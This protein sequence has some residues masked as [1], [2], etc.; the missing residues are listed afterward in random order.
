MAQ[1][2]RSGK[3]SVGASNPVLRYGPRFW[4]LPAAWALLAPLEK[5]A[6]H[7]TF[8]NSVHLSDSISSLADAAALRARV[9]ELEALLARERSRAEHLLLINEVGRRIGAI[10]NQEDLLQQVV[11]LIR[12]RLWY[13]RVNVLLVHGT[14]VVLRAAAGWSDLAAILGL[15]LPIGT[16]IVGWVAAHAEPLLVN[17]VSLDPRHVRESDPEE[18]WAELAVPIRLGERVLGVLDVQASERN[19]FTQDDVFT[20]E[21]LAD[22]IAV[23]LENARIY[24]AMDQHLAEVLALQEV[25]T[26]IMGERDARR[27]M[28]TVAKQA[29]SLLGC[30]T[31]SLELL[32]VGRPWLEVEVASGVASEQLLGTRVPLDASL[33]GHVLRTGR[34]LISHEAATDP[35]TH[36][37]TIRRT[38]ARSLLVAPMGLRGRRMGTISAY[39]KHFGQFTERDAELMALFGGQAAVAIENARLLDAERR[40]ARQAE[41]LARASITIN[42][43]LDLTRTLDVITRQVCETLDAERVAIFLHDP[44]SDTVYVGSTAGVSQELCDRLKPLRFSRDTAKAFRDTWSGLTIVVEDAEA[45]PE[46]NPVSRQMFGFRSFMATPL[47]VKGHYLG[48]LFVDQG[49]QLRH[50]SD[51]DRRLFEALAGPVA[52]AVENARLHAEAQRLAVVEERT[53]LARELH[54]SVT[55]SLF[56]AS[57]LAQ[58]AQSLWKRDPERAKERLDRAAE[59]CGGALA[60]MRALIF[61]LRPAALQEEGLVSALRKHAAAREA[62][63]GIAVEFAVEHERRLP[64]DCEEAAYRIVREALH[65]IVKH[66]RASAVRVR[67]DFQPDRLC[68]EVR[69][70]GQGFDVAAV[71]GRG[72]GLTSMRERA[73]QLGGSLTIESG[74]G[75]GTAIRAELPVPK[76]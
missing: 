12:Q 20:L 31:V 73:E 76:S 16:G 43:S 35:R 25:G 44:A 9:A 56:S 59:L 61:E 37:E 1:D 63:D 21:I 50:W 54:D 41:A 62:R 58:A 29:R 74:P 28:E 27:V 5:D 48:F 6:Y 30:E 32:A 75:R 42:S 49:S 23:A 52:T 51:D 18:S 7:Q 17:D 66:A 69:D 60:E 53:R 39:N 13:H 71:A 64:P 38:N 24:R 36:K 22:Q 55:Q 57:M 34:V 11:A 33:S 72:M 40:R 19:A 2:I 67:L 65:N 10:L 46:I 47:R 8:M 45:D 68:L 70:N 3:R 4:L 15:R 14:E 26:A